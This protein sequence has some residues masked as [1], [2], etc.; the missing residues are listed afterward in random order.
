MRARPLL[1]A[2]G[3]ALL[4]GCAAGPDYARPTVETPPAWRV[5]APWREARPSDAMPKGEWWKVFGDA[6]IGR[7]SCRERVFVG[8]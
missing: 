3:A 7:A 5:E 2:L 8:V 6:E 4:A 1:V